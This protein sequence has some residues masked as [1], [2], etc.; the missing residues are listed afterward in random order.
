MKN[1]QLKRL[2]AAVILGLCV[3][4]AMI[5]ENVYA[6]N[7]ETAVKQDMRGNVNWT[8][9][10]QANVTALGIGLP[11]ENAGAR[12]TALARRAAI[13]DA[14]RSLAETINGIQIDGDTVMEDLTIASDTVRAQVSALVKG[15]TIIDEGS[16]LD[17]SYYVEMSVPLYGKTGSLAAIAFPQM[18]AGDK[19][20]AAS[21]VGQ[22]S[23]SAQE[24]GE[25]RKVA[26][27]G[28][29]IDASGLGLSPT[30]SPVIY[31]INGRAIYGV[32]NI[33]RDLAISQGMVEYSNDLQAATGGDTRAGENPLVIKAQLVKGGKN[34][35]NKVNVVVSVEDGD[36]ILIA[37]E[38]TAVLNN[39]SVVFVK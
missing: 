35:I 36:R 31:D 34:S 23:L 39:G 29:V 15:A 2:A 10:S 24:V 19:E 8:K 5:P 17:G 11:P 33:D 13:V 9:G 3:N 18:K 38:E 14:Y 26:Y 20:Q 4:A 27:T 22:T 37:D 12:G 28:V 30:F 21:A 32:R 16:N 25:L 1:I 7:M 6:N